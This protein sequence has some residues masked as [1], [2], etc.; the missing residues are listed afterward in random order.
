MNQENIHNIFRALDKAHPDPETELDFK[1]KFTLL[2]AVVLSAQS[3]D[4]GVNRATKELFKTVDTP[5]KM[6][7]LGIDGV[8]EHIKTIGL[9]NNKAKYVIGLSK[10]II[11]E[12]D[13]QVPDNRSDLMSLPGVGRKTANVVLNVA[14]DQTTMPV[15][16]HVFRVA[17]R[18]GMSNGDTPRQVEK[19]LMEILP[20]EYGVKAHHLLI[21]HGRYTCKARTPQCPNCTIRE[22]CDYDD[23]TTMEELS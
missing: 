4:A 15:D 17:N 20:D 3:T 22:Y 21:L 9:Y 8:K 14:Y 6:V 12:F 10:K 18:M 5:E 1:N 16:T 11:N 7:E 19:D 23:K 2:V 13:G